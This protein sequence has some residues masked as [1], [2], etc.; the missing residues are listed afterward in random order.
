[1]RKARG[2]DRRNFDSLKSWGIKLPKGFVD[3]RRQAERRQP[4]V[5][6]ASLEEFEALMKIAKEKKPA[7]VEA[8]TSGFDS[9]TGHL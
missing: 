7:G 4:E 8:P 1:M 5:G 9:L 3:R 6:E 2:L